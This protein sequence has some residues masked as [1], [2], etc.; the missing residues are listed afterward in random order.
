MKKLV[1]LLAVIALA[2]PLYAAE[3]D[4]N[5]VITCTDEGNGVCRVDYQVLA[6]DGDPGLV[7]GFALDIEVSGNATI[8]A[9]SDYDQTGTATV[10]PDNYGVFVGQIDF[11]TDPNN[12]DDWGSPLA[13]TNT[14]YGALPSNGMTVELA[15]LYEMG[16]DTAPAPSGT[17]LKFTADGG[18]DADTTVTITANALRGEIVMED[19][20]SANI[21]S[22]GCT[23]T[24]DG[25][26]FPAAGEGGTTAYNDWLAFG[27]PE[28][29]CEA[30]QCDGDANGQ[31]QLVGGTVRVG[32]DDIAVV[33]AAWL[34]KEPPKGPGLLGQVDGNGRL[35]ICA[36]VNHA[37]QLVGGTVR[38]GPDDIAVIAANWLIKEPPKGP[39][40]PGTC[41]R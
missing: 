1:C 11:G 9:V 33:A 35:L 32:P 28:C 17:L 39:G 20:S 6:E 38:V 5:V 19:V 14:A 24:F 27:S 23:I 34:I 8:T 37:S 16:V 26:C 21:I 3:G 12:V 41:P 18:G 4:P 36:D 25:P 13:T 40:L 29:W 22:T 30:Y 10:A 31:T 2:A 7:R 15:S